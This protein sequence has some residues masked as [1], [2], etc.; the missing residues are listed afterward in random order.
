MDEIINFVA[1]K[2]MSTVNYFGDQSLALLNKVSPP[3]TRSE[4]INHLHLVLK[5]SGGEAVAWLHKTFPPCWKPA[6]ASEK[7]SYWQSTA[8][9]YGA[10]AV[11]WLVGKPY[12]IAAVVLVV[13]VRFFGG[14][15]KGKMMKAPGRNYKMPRR[16]FA[17]NPKGYFKD[18]R[19][20]RR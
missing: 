13:V 17:S 15:G 16:D 3:E 12:I 2:L 10:E 11:T 4:K 5:N 14:G 6:A 1:E 19:G 18:L 20:G 7:I 8:K 9:G